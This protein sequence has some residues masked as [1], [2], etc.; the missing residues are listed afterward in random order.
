MNTV[1][2]SSLATSFTSYALKSVSRAVRAPAFSSSAAAV[3][4]A[5]REPALFVKLRFPSFQPVKAFGGS[6]AQKLNKLSAASLFPRSF[7]SASSASSGGGGT[8]S[9]DQLEVKQQVEP[10]QTQSMPPGIAKKGHGPDE[11]TLRDPV[12]DLG[13][14]YKD[15]MAE[16]FGAG[17]H[18]RST[19]EGYGQ[20][21][22]EP[23]DEVQGVG[24]VGNAPAAWSEG[25][26]PG[27]PSDGEVPHGGVEYDRSQGSEV[28]QKEDA[29]HAQ[30]KNAFSN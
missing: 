18:S 3:Q 17:Y 1:S 23:V 22:G 25:K 6:G 9:S 16:A 13:E 5:S 7:S 4:V 19:D 30:E 27:K 2:L 20:I 26:G 14:A 29:R 24:T 28:A 8:M 21:Y 11:E 15:D 12:A 10:G